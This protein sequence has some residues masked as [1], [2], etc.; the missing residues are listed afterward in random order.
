[1][2]DFVLRGTYAMNHILMKLKASQVPVWSQ[3]YFLSRIQGYSN[4]YLAAG[5]FGVTT[6]ISN[7]H[8]RLVSKT[9]EHCLVKAFEA[10]TRAL[11]KVRGI[12]G[13]QQVEAIVVDDEFYNILSRYAG[14]TLKY[15]VSQKL[16]SLDQLQDAL[17]QVC[18]AIK[19]MHEAGVAHC[20]IHEENVCI[21][22]GEKRLQATIIDLGFA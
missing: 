16:L 14:Q 1:M 17:D 7:G 4:T 18:V 20:D 9:T 6:L 5:A 13:L 19:R 2:L 21:A 22:I 10:E 11:S 3:K 12:D 15:C 8:E